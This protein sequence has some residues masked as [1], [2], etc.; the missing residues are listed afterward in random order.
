MVLMVMI[1]SCNISKLILEN[2]GL[3]CSLH[4]DQEEHILS[5]P[6]N[7]VCILSQVLGVFFS[8][9]CSDFEYYFAYTI[10]LES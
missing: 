9:G 10:L 6:A 3:Y 8:L 2:I 7:F 5:K 1:L 4:V